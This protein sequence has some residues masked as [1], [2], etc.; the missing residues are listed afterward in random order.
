[1]RIFTCVVLHLLSVAVFVQFVPVQFAFGAVNLFLNSWY[2][3]PRLL[4]IGCTQQWDVD[5]RT[6]DGWDV[7]SIGLML[8]M[9]IVY[10]ECLGCD[11]FLRAVS[12]HFLYDGSILL[13]S[14]CYTFALSKGPRRSYAPVSA[15]PL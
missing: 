14:A 1:M 11:A 8:V 3:M 7:V 10:A 9:V 4:H 12:G 13:L 2:C 6:K 5:I 15:G